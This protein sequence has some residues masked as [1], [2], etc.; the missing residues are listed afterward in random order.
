M[1]K[2]CTVCTHTKRADID[3]AL[4]AGVSYRTLAAQYGPSP[5]ALC[6]HVRHL[7]RY[8]DRAHHHEDLKYHQAVLDKLDLLEVRLTRVFQDANQSNSLRVAL[9]C[10]KE[11]VKVLAL[12]GKFRHRPPEHP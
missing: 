9:E 5:S 10:I 6:R 3:R 11:H 7:S 4:M 8:L 12:Q 1:P 2:P